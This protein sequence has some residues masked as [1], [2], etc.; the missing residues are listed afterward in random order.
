LYE[1]FVAGLLAMGPVSS[2]QLVG[3]HETDR[4]R[5]CCGI[6]DVRSFNQPQAKGLPSHRSGQRIELD[7]I[8][9]CRGFIEGQGS[10][11]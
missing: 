8:R 10:S 9:R 1:Y 5:L 4:E 3:V 7:T 2:F 11:H 6:H